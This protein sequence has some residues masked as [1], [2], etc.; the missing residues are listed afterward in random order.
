MADKINFD[1]AA[2]PGHLL[3]RA[4]QFAAERFSEAADGVEVTP[5]QFAVLSAVA[6]DEGLTQTQL[7]KVTGV[8]RSTLAELVARM[9]SKGLLIR[10]KAPGDARANAIRFTDAGR[11]LYETAIAGA[12]QADEAILAALPKNKRANFV[13]A[14]VRIASRLDA[15]EARDNEAARRAKDAERKRDEKAKKK[16]KKKKKA[17]AKS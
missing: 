10:E 6:A 9:A 11:Q 8:D 12:A 13:D 15:D 3:H 16:K 14:L 7:V 17:R 2:S 1:L 5:R 4:T